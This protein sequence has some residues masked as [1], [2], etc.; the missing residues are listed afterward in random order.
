MIFNT[1]LLG[2]AC[3]DMVAIIL[4][5]FVHILHKAG[6]Y[7]GTKHLLSELDGLGG[8]SSEFSLEW[9]SHSRIV[10]TW[11]HSCASTQHVVEPQA[12]KPL[13]SRV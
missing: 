13:A 7:T 2:A 5:V 3:C 8:R 10:L 12:N 9:S 11:Q 4:Q 6:S 1:T